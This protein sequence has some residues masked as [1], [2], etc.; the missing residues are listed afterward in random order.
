MK[1]DRQ[2]SRGMER[3]ICHREG[4][5]IEGLFGLSGL[6]GVDNF[7]ELGSLLSEAGFSGADGHV[8]KLRAEHG[9]ACER[10]KAALP[11]AARATQLMEENGG[12]LA[13][14]FSKIG[15]AIKKVAKVAVKLSPSHQI[16]KKIKPLAKFSP[17]LRVAEGRTPL[18]AMA[19]AKPVTLDAEVAAQ[20]A[21]DKAAAKE[22]KRQAKLAK[23]QAKADA[24]AAKKKAKADAAAAAA[25][26]QANVQPGT[27]PAAAGAQV[28][29]NQSGVD[30]SSPTGQQF[31]M[32][33]AANAAYPGS[34]VPDASM[35][36]QPQADA[37]AD[38][39][40]GISPVVL[41]GGGVAAL[42]LLMF[43]MKKRR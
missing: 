40:G 2:I 18:I 10:I 43:A 38:S 13:G 9:C 25:L 3:V 11:V 21:A 35:F 20:V 26:A 32:Q 7:A 33:A 17:A 15:K 39:G 24:K 22:A 23:K 5:R 36:S 8:R 6:S 42:G 28:L 4:S 34:A 12:D 19:T 27:P 16:I 29:A 1:I 14:I 31:A 37:A 41:I 30:L